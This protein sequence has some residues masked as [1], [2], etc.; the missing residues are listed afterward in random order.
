MVHVTFRHVEST[1]ALQ[2]TIER[3]SAR[4]LKLIEYPVEIFWRV[5][6][7]K[8]QHSAEITCRAEHRTLVA[9]A[10]TKNLYD[11]LEEAMQRI[12][13]Q[14]RRER[15]RHRGK[16]AANSTRRGKSLRHGK[17]VGEGYPHEMKQVARRGR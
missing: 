6:L 10:V 8:T 1:P 2:E 3:K 16:S 11:S 17:D 4:I 5:Q 7:E 15:E 14:L 12:L 9:V 13:V